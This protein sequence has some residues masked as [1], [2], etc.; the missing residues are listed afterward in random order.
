MSNNVR[1]LIL[2]FITITLCAMINDS[3]LAYQLNQS[4]II[5]D[6]PFEETPPELLDSIKTSIEAEPAEFFP[7]DH[8]QITSVRFVDDWGMLYIIALDETKT[9]EDYFE[10]FA[11]GKLVLAHQENLVWISALEGTQ[12]FQEVINQSPSDLITDESKSI[13][14]N[15]S[16]ISESGLQKTELSSTVEY[17]FPWTKDHSWKWW[18]RDSSP[19]WHGGRDCE[20]NTND[21]AYCAIDLGTA[22]NNKTLL[23]AAGG[24]VVVTCNKPNSKTINIKITDD[25]GLSINY[26]H[27]NKSTVDF[28]NIYT[29]AE[30]DRATPLGNVWNGDL[31]ESW[32]DCG[33]AYQYPNNGHVHLV[34]PTTPFVIDGWTF[35]YPSICAT[36]GTETKCT[37]KDFTSTNEFPVKGEVLTPVPNAMLSGTVQITGSAQADND[38]V[39]HVEIWINGAYRGNA[40]YLESYNFF[41]DWVTNSAVY[42]D[43]IYTIQVKGVMASGSFAW[44]SFAGTGGQ[45]SV[46]VII[47]NQ[48]PGIPSTVSSNCQS[49]N[50]VWQNSCPNPSFT[51]SEP[52]DPGVGISG[53]K[54][55]WG[56]YPYGTPDILLTNR[57]FTPPPVNSTQINY[58]RLQSQNA[59]G[60]WSNPSTIFVFRYDNIPPDVT[61]VINQGAEKTTQV[62]ISLDINAFDSHS[63]IYQMRLTNYPDIW[64]NPR[65]DF[66][67]TKNWNIFPIR[68]FPQNIYI[69]V[70]DKAGNTSIASDAIVF[71]PVQPLPYSSN[72]RLCGDALSLAGGVSLSS[73]YQMVFNLGQNAVS[74]NNSG[75]YMQNAG[76]LSD[77]NACWMPINIFHGYTMQQS[78]VAAAGGLRYSNQYRMGGTFGQALGMGDQPSTSPSSQHLSGYWA[79]FDGQV[80]MYQASG[81]Q[82][83]TPIIPPNPTPQPIPTPVPEAYRVIINNG[84]ASTNNLNLQVNLQAPSANQVRLS[85]DPVEGEDGWYP[86]QTSF[87]WL[88][89]LSE[90]DTEAQWTRVY[91]WFKNQD[92]VIMGPYND[93]ILFDPVAPEGYIEWAGSEMLP[94]DIW[95]YATD[96]GSG[97]EVMRWGYDEDLS[98]SEWTPYT[99]YVSADA[100]NGVVYAQFRDYAGNMSPVYAAYPVNYE[101]QIFLPIIKK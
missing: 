12:K 61:A 11:S 26:F 32:A 99:N 72:Y 59:N 5:I 22:N 51:W 75:E 68:T 38:Y 101:T 93:E 85:N 54:I 81:L 25:D 100:S 23:A 28:K 21:P 18:T 15:A 48:G 90:P 17:R 45:T 16:S 9:G 20:N 89:D 63:G 42:K 77:L 95:L 3:A 30:I 71:D 60:K 41:W 73:N 97:V 84:A 58:L 55:Y 44:L 98:T 62:S 8:F 79:N 29:S 10:N 92:D 86:Y 83:P 35:D 53:Y 13:L 14:L 43:D 7:G 47:D 2:I 70:S 50:D 78:V 57:S 52:V 74:H 88:G 76:V 1:K 64:P 82:L 91:A 65:V 96:M 87:S 31:P 39:D 80:P 49:K 66:S 37:G 94:T 6:S 34:I 40:I 36:K 27:I 19:D 33:I 24:T 67:S 46:T 56:P 69:E 4:G